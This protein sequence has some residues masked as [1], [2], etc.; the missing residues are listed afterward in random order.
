MSGHSGRKSVTSPPTS[1]GRASKAASNAVDKVLA[2][3]NSAADKAVAVV[4]RNA[5]GA[6]TRSTPSSIRSLRR[7]SSQVFTEAG[8]VLA[9]G[10]K[11]FTE[12]AVVAQQRLSNACVVIGLTL[13]V[14]LL[15]VL[16]TGASL[17]HK[18]QIGPFAWFTLKRE[19]LWELT[20][21]DLLALR[22]T[23][24]L[25]PFSLWIISS[26]LVPA[27]FAYLVVFGRSH[28]HR[29]RVLKLEDPSPV[30]FSIVR[31]ALSY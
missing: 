10:Q 22:Q 30:T 24:F 6:S 2:Q 12:T 7:R 9:D 4:D 31:L 18:H 28:N 13:A 5:R 1:V 27:A 15:F 8:K 23:T 19:F 16:F 14:E 17:V 20:L 11:S 21:P 26:I 29:R 25:Q 3:A